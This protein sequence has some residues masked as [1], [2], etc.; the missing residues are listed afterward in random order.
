MQGFCFPSFL[1][2]ICQVGY[3][4]CYNSKQFCTTLGIFQRLDCRQWVSIAAIEIIFFSVFISS[5]SRQIYQ[6]ARQIQT[7]LF[8]QRNYIMFLQEICTSWFFRFLALTDQRVRY[9]V[10]LNCSCKSWSI[11]KTRD[12]FLLR[13]LR[14][15]THDTI[16]LYSW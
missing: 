16:L 6:D 3:T 10:L 1:D 13:Y 12:R 14:L 2:E 7:I 5:L 9:F 11:I 4:E 15:K 8:N